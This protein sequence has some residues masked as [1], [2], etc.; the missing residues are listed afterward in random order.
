MKEKGIKKYYTLIGRINKE[1][2]REHDERIYKMITTGLEKKGFYFSNKIDLEGFIERN[3]SVKDI[4]SIEKRIYYV[5]GTPFL[6][7][8]YNTELI[9]ETKEDGS[10]TIKVEL[11]FYYF[12]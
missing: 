5:Y 9:T 12:I 2:S 7:Q 4:P 1:V 6:G 8:S 10:V 3:C 11:G